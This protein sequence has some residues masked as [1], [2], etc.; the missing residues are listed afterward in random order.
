MMQFNISNLSFSYKDKK[1]LDNVNFQLKEG[2]LIAL[3]GR[4]GSGKTTLLRLLLGFLK[5]KQGKLAIDGTNIENIPLQQRAKLIAYIPQFSDIAFPTTI[6]NSVVMGR[7]PNLALFRNPT[8]KDIEIAKHFIKLMGIEKLEDRSIAKVSGG[9]KQL[10]LIA[11]ALTQE[12]KILLMDEPT[13]A[14]DYSNQ[15]MVLETIEKLKTNGYSILFST[16]NPEQALM[17]SSSIL[18]LDNGK[19]EFY[20]DKKAL[21]DGERL[22]KLY[23]QELYIKE[24]DTGLNRRV[25]CIPK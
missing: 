23:N 13:A 18:I 25:I 1:V 22:S 19:S 12:A 6:L 5:P 3:L 11:R 4:N 15:L 16:H 21:L 8:N 17:L 14:L 2:E 10:A 24:V 20:S 7:T 9:E